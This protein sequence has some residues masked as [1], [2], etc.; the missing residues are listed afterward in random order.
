M[1][2]VITRKNSPSVKQMILLVKLA[3]DSYW[4]TSCIKRYNIFLCN[5]LKELLKEKVK[6]NEYELNGG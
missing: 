3:G 1:I 2:D 4:R 6:L 5:R